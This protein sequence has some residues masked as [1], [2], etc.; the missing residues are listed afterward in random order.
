VRIG[1]IVGFAFLIWLSVCGEVNA[2]NVVS[3]TI[4]YLLWLVAGGTG[5]GAAVTAVHRAKKVREQRD[6]AEAILANQTGRSRQSQDADLTVFAPPSARPESEILIQVVVHTPEREDEAKSRALMIEPT[7]DEL[8]SIPLTI[9]L[10]QNDNIK[11]T[12]DCEGAKVFE[13]AQNANWNGRI[14]C[15]YFMM[16]LPASVSEIILLPKLRVFVNAVPAGF[17]V[18][19]IKVI[20]NARNQPLT[21]AQIERQAFKWAFLSY[22]SEDRVEVLKAAQLISA[23]RMRYFQD[24]L[25]ESPGD[26]WR[27]RMFSEIDKC[28]VF[29]LFWS[30]HAQRS[31]WVLREAQYALKRSKSVST[32][33]PIEIVPVLLEGPPPPSPPPSLQEIHFNDP[34]RYVIFAE[35]SVKERSNDHDPADIQTQTLSRGLFLKPVSQRPIPIGVVDQMLAIAGAGG[36]A[37]ATPGKGP[38]QADGGKRGIGTFTIIL[39]ALTITIVIVNLI[40][41]LG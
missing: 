21:V 14:V 19:K 26:Q 2:A 41:I 10:N 24:V 37:D 9:Q 4:E 12:L 1:L 36:E 38:V 7:A 22:A 5:A 20:P 30:K 27:E 13:P 39:I 34:I 33:Q 3:E 32:D 23:L 28:D 6:L 18:F 17:V 11:L 29:L 15:L 16:K 40:R 31:E 25:S 35:E 8:A